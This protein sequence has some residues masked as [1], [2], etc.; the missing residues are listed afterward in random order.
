MIS[1]ILFGITF[2]V[3][4]LGKTGSAVTLFVQLGPICAI[5]GEVGSVA[6]FN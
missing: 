6:A 2:E 4:F 5:L 3:T 1:E